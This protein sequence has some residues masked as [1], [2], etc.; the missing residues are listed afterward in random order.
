MSALISP[1]APGGAGHLVGRLLRSRLAAALATPHGVDRYLE[2]FNPMWAAHEV[3]A[4]VVSVHRETSGTDSA[5][6]ATLTLQPTSTWRGHRAGQHV[7]VGVELPGPEGRGK[8]HTRAFSISSAAS[9]PGEQFTLTIRA[10]DEGQVSSYLVREAQP[11]TLLHLSQAQG[12]FTLVESPATPTISRLLFITGGSGITPAMSMVRTL[13]RDGY[14]GHAGRRVTFLHFARSPED[15]IF[16][17]ELAEIAAADNG[18]DVHLRYAD[19][20]F[21]E[22]ELRR[23]VPDYRDTDTWLC[24]PAGLVELV[25]DAYTD[26]ESS[27]GELSPR[28]RME[29]FKPAVARAAAPGGEIEGEVSFTRSGATT[30]ATGAS[31]L[32][33]AEELGLKPEFGCRMGICFSC[34]RTKSAGT[35]RNV[36]TGEESSLPD[37]EIRICVTAAAGDCHIDL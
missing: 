2:R 15:Q 21:S 28:L 37:E 3:R 31:L 36:L 1:P 14:D 26:P 4:R 18:V 23:L 5:P 19:Q 34:T 27:G 16:A 9:A 20:L 6:V 30:A 11:G 33:Q 10:H 17:D 25:K 29:F 22:F 12:E 8:R 32:E 24:G 7:L 13:L 35:V